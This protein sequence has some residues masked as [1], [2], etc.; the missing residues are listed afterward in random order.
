MS[1]KDETKS[2]DE[3]VSVNVDEFTKTRDSVS[4][5]FTLLSTHCCFGRASGSSHLAFVNNALFLPPM[6]S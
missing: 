6:L 4:F 5:D 3:T 1:S 2:K